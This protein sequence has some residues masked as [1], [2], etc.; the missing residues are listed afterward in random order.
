M[1]R[2]IIKFLNENPNSFDL[3]MWALDEKTFVVY[4]EK[5]DEL[6]KK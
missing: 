1:Y 3:I 2:E 5:F 4:K 6:L